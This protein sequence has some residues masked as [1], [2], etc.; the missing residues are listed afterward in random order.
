VND[1]SGIVQT[2]ATGSAN[3]LTDVAVTA[4]RQWLPIL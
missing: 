4:V 1:E 2:V 3:H